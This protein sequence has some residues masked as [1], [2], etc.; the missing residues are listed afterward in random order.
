MPS[1]CRIRMTAA[2]PSPIM[3]GL[4]D[5]GV[6]EEA[7]A[8]DLEQTGEIDITSEEEAILKAVWGIFIRL[9]IACKS[10]SLYNANH[11]AAWEAVD[12]FYHVLSE[13]LLSSSPIRAQVEK[14]TLFYDGF[15]I[16]QK[17]EGLRQLASRL[18][19][20]NIQE[21][22]FD[23]G[24]TRQEAEA[25]VELL[26]SDP[27]EVDAKGGAETFLLLA[28]VQGIRLVESA[29]RRAREKEPE[30][31]PGTALG[32]PAGEEREDEPLPPETGYF[33]DLLKDPEELSRT[34]SQLPGDEDLALSAEA[35]AETIFE[36]LRHAY[37]FLEE[38]HPGHVARACRSMAE[39]L[40]YLEA[41][42]RNLLLLQH[43]FPKLQ[44]EPVCVA[45]LEQFNVK[46]TVDLLASF[47]CSHS[48][49]LPEARDLLAAIGY[50]G[51][52]LERAVAL[53]KEK[54]IYL[55]EL[56][57]SAIA[58][59]DEGGP[60]SLA[61]HQL[62][63]LDEISSSFNRY[64]QEEIEEIRRISEFDLAR[65]TLLDA[66]P[67]LLDLL[68]QADRL[69]NPDPVIELLQQNFWDL[70][71][72]AR[73]AEA[74]DVLEGVRLFLIREDHSLDRFRP[75][76]S[77]LM[78]EAGSERVVDHAIRIT[79]ERRNDL[80]AVE[81]LKKYFSRLGDR[82]IKAMVETLGNE[83]VMAIRKYIIDNL[84]ELGKDHMRLLG[85]YVNDPRWYLVRNIVTILAGIRDPEAIPYL[86]ATFEHPNPKVRAETIRALGMIGGYEAVELLMQG[87]RSQDEQ[88]RI[89]CIRWLGRLE[90]PRAAGQLVK[91][92][93]G[94]EHG[95]ESLR[96]KKEILAC[97][98]EIRAPETYPAIL[99]HCDMQR[100]INRAEW[101]E[102]NEVARH[103]LY[104]LLEKYPHL[105][106]KR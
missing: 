22:I 30:A 35:M 33:L 46:E 66:T 23:A 15:P 4:K 59:L 52:E 75:D 37:S 63:T 100:R 68:G 16:G 61:G 13:A 72:S 51:S 89:L 26:I 101:Q 83:D 36:F 39:A 85:A 54:L 11:P 43:L 97:L 34:L 29:A 49:L 17:S 73:L 5:E 98:G 88:A 3:R 2:I 1:L 71:G 42:L 86:R 106:R 58:V 62:P 7:R 65:E 21:V 96:V 40:L 18:R 12:A 94:K 28:G 80:Q 91:M 77:R 82:G 60:E 90:E 64:S 87:L 20:L 50:R 53:L 38:E 25:L 14:E 47:F 92:L 78:G 84:V 10:R 99:K 95:A 27:G 45:M 81:G 102:V 41:E 6:M 103:A 67:M 31:Q 69:D 44:E 76:L 104:C 24:L 19:S 105:G 32:R 9:S 70:L 56:P 57:L 93:E 79:Y 48:E 55:A 8:R 74:A